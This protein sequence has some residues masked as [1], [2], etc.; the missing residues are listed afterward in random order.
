MDSLEVSGIWWHVLGI[1]YVVS[2]SAAA[3]HALLKKPEPQSALTWVGLIFLSP[4]IG[5]VLYVLFGVNRIKRR[6]Q[7][8]KQRR[9]PAPGTASHAFMMPLDPSTNALTYV[10]DQLCK[11][12]LSHGNHIEPLF[13]GDIAM[14]RMLDALAGARECVFLSSYI[15][16][17]DVVGKRFVRALQ[18]A[19]DRGVQ[20]RVLV[21]GVGSLYSLPPIT[22]ALRKAQ[23]PVATFL[24]TFPPWYLSFSNLR[25]HRKLLIVDGNLAFTGG[26]NIRHGQWPSL[27]P[28]HPIRDLHFQLQGPVVTELQEIFFNDWH[29]A[30]GESLS[31]PEWPASDLAAGNSR[32]RAIADGPDE[33][34]D[35]IRWLLHGAIAEAKQCIRIMTPYF[36]PDSTLIAALN[37]AALRGIRV[38][39]VLPESNNLPWM[40]WAMQ[41]LIGQL[42]QKG[43]HV[44]W[45]PAPFEHSKLMI[46]DDY[47][48]LFGSANWD[49]RSLRLNFELNIECYD[50][51]LS[52]TMIGYF[53]Q[54]LRESRPI[55]HGDT[56]ILTLPARLRNS[57]AR[58]FQPIL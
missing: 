51:D 40:H 13:G 25:F 47:W 33:R 6:A 10:G 24:P 30:A 56:Q 15:F 4:F 28:K 14:P 36:T 49:T 39:I 2:A 38:D 52:R 37:T 22:T 48:F 16:D 11:A 19:L 34:Y 7:R 18:G 20:V 44:F 1:A 29:F 50:A 43:C 8:L 41:A 12:L 53:D 9:L 31:G 42:L 3:V 55:S 23:I 54:R 57:I 5:T 26:M 17:N 58:L 35:K 27:R 32:V 45:S 21:D 46:I